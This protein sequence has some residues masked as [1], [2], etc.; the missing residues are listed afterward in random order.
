[1]N[2]KNAA[3]IVGGSAQFVA[4]VGFMATPFTAPLGAILMIHGSNNLYEGFTGN[5]GGIKMIY[6][7]MA[8]NEDDGNFAYNLV[9]LTISL[10]SLNVG[11]LKPRAFKL[12]RYDRSLKSVDFVKKYRTLTKRG[13]LIESGTAASSVESLTGGN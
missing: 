12:F 6:Q 2:W 9:D 3:A 11:V 5:D 7:L 8:K 10:G 13:L 1:M 4:G